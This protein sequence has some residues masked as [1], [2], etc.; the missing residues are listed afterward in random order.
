MWCRFARDIRNQYTI[1]YT[2]TNA[3]QDGGFRAIQVK[4]KAPGQ[5]HLVLRTRPGYYAT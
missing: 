3:T 5:D 1:A 2:P 4:A